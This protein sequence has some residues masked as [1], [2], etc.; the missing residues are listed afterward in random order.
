MKPL[1]VALA[2]INP[3]VGDIRANSRKILDR[4]DRAKK[5]NASLVVFPELAVTGYPPED[6][7]LRVPFVEK[8]VEAWKE[9][10]GRVKG[11]TAVVGFVDRD[12]RGRNYNAAGIAS[13]GRVRAVY[14]KM[15]LPNYGVFD[16]VRY[17]SA[18]REPML[19]PAGR[20]RIG[21]TV[22]EDI[23]VS[24]GPLPRE[25]KAGARLIL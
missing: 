21:V 2:Q 6:L 14:H 9:I 23:W 11:I 16:E 15:K 18:G 10:A 8:N 22:C 19:F 12:A 3:T 24:G 5:A 13:G 1:R 25:A 17:F 4:V 20:S 7:L